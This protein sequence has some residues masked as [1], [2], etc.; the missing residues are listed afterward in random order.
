MGILSLFINIYQS[1]K[2]IGLQG[3]YQKAQVILKVRFIAFRKIYYSSMDRVRVTP[4][5]G[6]KGAN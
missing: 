4:P 1:G 2:F 3:V 5:K 6:I